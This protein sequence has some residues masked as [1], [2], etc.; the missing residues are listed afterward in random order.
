MEYV[1]AAFI[2]AVP[3][4]LVLGV[5]RFY[6]STWWSTILKSMLLGVGYLVVLTATLMGLLLLSVLY[7]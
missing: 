4:H 3:A 2:L 7:L 5:K 1:G 6:G